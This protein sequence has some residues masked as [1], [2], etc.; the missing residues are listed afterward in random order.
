MSYFTNITDLSLLRKRYY[1][2]ALQHHPDRGGDLQTM[3]AI[4]REYA[5]C[6]EQLIKGN[7][8]FS[9][10]R[11]SYEQEV[12]EELKQKINQVIHFQGIHIEVIGGWLWITGNTF[13]LKKNSEIWS[14]DIAGISQPGTG[15][16][17]TTSR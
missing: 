6:S 13:P 12:S 7:T 8:Q 3:Q 14:F 5:Q 4:N 15:I 1:Q 10:L 16:P 9:N 17:E 11:K 2:L